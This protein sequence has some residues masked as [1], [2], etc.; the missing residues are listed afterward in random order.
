MGR[1]VEVTSYRRDDGVTVKRGEW[2]LEEAEV[3]REAWYVRLE[4][5]KAAEGDEEAE[6]VGDDEASMSR[7]QG[8]R[9]LWAIYLGDTRAGGAGAKVGEGDA[10]N[11][12]PRRS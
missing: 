1:A 8:A 12:C 5:W 7:L 6:T 9:L 3:R 4:A 10:H 11:D 2:V